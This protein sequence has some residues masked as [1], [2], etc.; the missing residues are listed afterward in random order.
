MKYMYKVAENENSQVD[1]TSKSSKCIT[2]IVN[3][4]IDKMSVNNEKCSSQ[5]YWKIFSIQIFRYSEKGNK[6]SQSRY[7]N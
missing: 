1:S 5:F 2:L 3:S 7:C 6:S 4:T